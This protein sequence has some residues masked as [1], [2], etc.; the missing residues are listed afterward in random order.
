MMMEHESLDPLLVMAKRS[1]RGRNSLTPTIQV[2]IDPVSHSKRD[3]KAIGEI[4]LVAVAEMH[5]NFAIEQEPY[6]TTVQG[7]ELLL[8]SFTYDHKLGNRI[9][10]SRAHYA[11]AITSKAE[12]TF[13]AVGAASGF[14]ECS[15]EFGEVLESLRF[16]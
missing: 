1:L 12:F 11:I 4:G 14:D 10:R 7:T 15:R 16:E 5:R 3:F 9:A 2:L 6:A 13:G 8:S